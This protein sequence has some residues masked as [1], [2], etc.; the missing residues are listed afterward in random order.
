M[1]SECELCDNSEEVTSTSDGPEEVGVALL[2]GL[3]DASISKH[4]FGADDLIDC[5]TIAAS[6][7][8][9]REVCISMS[10]YVKYA[11]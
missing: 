11:L 3:D 7:P 1:C 9:A 5:K 4:N 6:E 8:S 2:A 10:S